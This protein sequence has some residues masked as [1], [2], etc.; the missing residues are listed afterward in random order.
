MVR[1]GVSPLCCG[2]GCASVERPNPRSDQIGS[3]ADSR[4]SRTVGLMEFTVTFELEPSA[5]FGLPQEG[6]VVLPVN[7]D[8]S[9]RN[10]VTGGLGISPLDGRVVMTLDGTAVPI[11][12]VGCVGGWSAASWSCT[13]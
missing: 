1:P 3:P 12:W 4:P 7:P 5:M 11:L 2:C 8:G 6:N 13:S 10:I 9:P